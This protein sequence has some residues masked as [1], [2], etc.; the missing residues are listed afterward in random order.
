MSSDLIDKLV[1]HLAELPGIGKKTALRLA[2]EI[3]RKD[4]M[5]AYNFAQ[6]LIDAKQ[7][8]R[9]CKVCGN[10]CETEV[11][12]ICASNVRNQQIICVVE[13]YQDVLAI[14][15]TNTF[16]GVY[17]V[18]GGLISPINGIGPSQ[19][20]I[21]SLL[22]RI[23]HQPIDEVILALN[24]TPEGE[25]TSFY[26]CKKISNISDVKIT[27]LAKGISVGEDLNYADEITLSRS[28]LNRVPLQIK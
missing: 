23:S 3:I 6:S 4:E 8:L 26:L 24:A 17:H 21:E 13:D 14:E 5:Y 16:N 1:Q 28:I 27:T 2:L 20:N 11:C 9:K 25:S 12:E 18:L 7:K 10:I 22:E 15:G 19:L